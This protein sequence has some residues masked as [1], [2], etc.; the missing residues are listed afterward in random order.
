MLH[1]LKDQAFLLSFLF[2]AMPFPPFICKGF[3]LGEESTTIVGI[4]YFGG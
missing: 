4:F 2:I 3:S 1:I